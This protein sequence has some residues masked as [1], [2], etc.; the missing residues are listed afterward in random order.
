MNGHISNIVPKKNFGFIKTNDTEYFFHRSDFH[1]H[2]EDL[3]KDFNN[4]KRGE[5]IKVNFDEAQSSK[6]PRAANVRRED[7]PNQAV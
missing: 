3:E 1:G 6:G 7:F 2:W 5:V 4:K